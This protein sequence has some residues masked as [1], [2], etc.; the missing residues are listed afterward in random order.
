MPSV[1]FNSLHNRVNL[2]GID[3]DLYSGYLSANDI[4][5]IADVPRYGS[6][7]THQQIAAG[8]P[9]HQRP[10]ERWQRPLDQKK[11]SE[12][13]EIYGSDLVNNL[14]PN[15][16]ILASVPPARGSTLTPP[17]PVMISL[18]GIDQA[19][20]NLY[21]FNIP[22][23]P[24]KSIW[25]LDGQHRIFGMRETRNPDYSTDRSD[26]PIPFILLHGDN[27]T[28][29]MLAE[30]FTYV[31][32]KATEMNPIHRAWMHYS[33][34]IPEY[35]NQD[36]LDSME[37]V[38]H[39]CTESN[40]GPMGGTPAAGA[41]NNPFYD[42]IKFN[43]DQ[44]AGFYAFKFDAKSLADEIFKNYY[45]NL[46]TTATR[47]GP[48]ELAEQIV[49]SVKAFEY[50]DSHKNGS[51]DGGSR[52]FDDDAGSPPLKMLADCYLQ[53]VLLHLRDNNS[54][55]FTGW[56][57][58]LGDGIRQFQN[59]DWRLLWLGSLDGTNQL[60]SKRVAIKVFKHYLSATGALPNRIVDYL[61]G[62]GSRIEVVSYFWDPVNNRKRRG[63]RY[64]TGGGIV[65]VG[66]RNL[67]V[68]LGTAVSTRTGV[69]VKV[70][71][72]V[73]N[74]VIKAVRDYD[75]NPNQELSGVKKQKGI[76]IDGQ[77]TR[78]SYGNADEL[79]IVIETISFSGATSDRTQIRLD[80]Y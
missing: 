47:L 8:I 6:R 53:A 1:E 63:A 76:D 79:N 19:A 56:K 68:P 74:I 15:P 57:N 12:I 25:I 28:A 17:R 40:F 24:N 44:Q 37:A 52:L 42:N 65:N 49:Y 27:Y 54:T 59:N 75:I 31:T 10:V 39:L 29:P 64:P 48:L 32:S 22:E 2:N 45:K 50:H 21:K 16:V 51:V 23:T 34:E 11:V 14:M 4:L 30:I 9:P 46:P 3:Y 72:G 20:P 18:G 70:P 55:S 62:Q 73:H 80:K 13:A 38:T 36:R 5:S 69:Y 58:L 41:A 33:F 66:A 77:L 78:T 67:S 35:D 60:D 61:R 71:D 26:L 43:P 7:Q